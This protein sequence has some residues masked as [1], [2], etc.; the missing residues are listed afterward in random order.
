[1]FGGKKKE[2]EISPAPVSSDPMG[3]TGASSE[4]AGRNFLRPDAAIGN[5]SRPA[6]QPDIG[7]RP[8]DLSAFAPRR[9]T[10][11][12]SRSDAES[13]KLIVGRDISLNGEIR[14]CDVLVVEGR[15]EASLSDCRSMEIAQTGHV[16]GNATVELA[17]ISG[18]FNGELT[19]QG[20]LLVRMTGRVH[21]KIRYHELEVERGGVIS[22]SLEI[23]H[24]GVRLAEA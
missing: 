6:P 10:P 3:A 12:P 14:T 21:G 1:M 18:E 8:P 15:V 9:E 22:G 16:K 4:S 13:K 17:D 2:Q 19:V 5:I 11:P 20:K 7:R 23:L 24:E